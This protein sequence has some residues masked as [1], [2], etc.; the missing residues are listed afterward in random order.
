MGPSV[1]SQ[2]STVVL[3]VCATRA[4]MMRAVEMVAKKT[5]GIS[6]GHGLVVDSK[7]VFNA[8]SFLPIRLM[9]VLVTRND[10]YGRS[11]RT[12]C[13]QAIDGVC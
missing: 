12:G 5:L 7:V 2:I 10:T 1:G 13:N 11:T 9:F 8:I 4:L 6:A 3:Q